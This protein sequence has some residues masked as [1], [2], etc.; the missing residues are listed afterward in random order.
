MAVSPGSARLHALSATRPS[1]PPHGNGSGPEPYRLL[2][3]GSDALVLEGVQAHD[4]S[5]AGCLA[6]SIA[7]LTGHGVDADVL[8]A[9]GL[10]IG[11][12]SAL[13][14]HRSLR[15]LDGIVLVLTPAVG[16]RELAGFGDRLRQL[17]NELTARLPPAPVIAVAVAPPSHFSGAVR[18][19]GWEKERYRA[20]AE[21]VAAATRPVAEFVQLPSVPLSR[22]A[23]RY[24]AWANRI[25]E[26]LAAPLG[27]PSRRLRPPVLEAAP[28]TEVFHAQSLIVLPVVHEAAQRADLCD[29]DRSNPGW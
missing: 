14:A 27:A 9:H 19:L 10:T 3:V 1:G 18:D 2:V 12:A 8:A 11:R 21:T 13:L 22:A 17:L 26:R 25:G 15:H 16:G 28:E 29:L 24:E 6:R 20:F 7:T 5:L 4:R 23:D